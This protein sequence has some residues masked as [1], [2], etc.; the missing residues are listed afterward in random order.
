MRVLV[1]VCWCACACVCVGV[2][3]LV[4]VQCALCGRGGA[5]AFFAVHVLVH[6]CK[7]AALTHVMALLSYLSLYLFVSSFNSRGAADGRSFARVG[8]AF[9]QRECI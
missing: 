5:C 4:C 8:A 7:R 3:A 9:A 2:R 6:V 1:C